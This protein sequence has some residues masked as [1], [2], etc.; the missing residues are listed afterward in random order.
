MEQVLEKKTMIC[1]VGEQV[2]Y[3]VFLGMCDD[4]GYTSVGAVGAYE[5]DVL[6]FFDF[7]NQL[8]SLKSWN[9]PVVTVVVGWSGLTYL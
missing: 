5:F 6:W 3:G 9:S 1:G 8:S 2:F 7:L 4:F